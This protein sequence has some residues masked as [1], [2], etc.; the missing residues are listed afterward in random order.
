MLCGLTFYFV[1]F[2]KS[3]SLGIEVVT[4]VLFQKKIMEMIQ[5]FSNIHDVENY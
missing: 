4:I 5:S 2:H 3:S 1:P